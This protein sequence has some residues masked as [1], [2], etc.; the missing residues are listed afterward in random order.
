MDCRAD[1]LW[2]GEGGPGERRRA[3]AIDGASEHAEAQRSE[4]VGLKIKSRRM[5]SKDS[6]PLAPHVESRITHGNVLDPR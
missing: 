3:S 5:T 2:V 6:Q 4:G 1:G